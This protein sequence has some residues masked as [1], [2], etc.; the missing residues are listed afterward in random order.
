MFFLDEHVVP[1]VVVRNQDLPDDQMLKRDLLVAT[2]F[3]GNARRI[4]VKKKSISSELKQPFRSS[5]KSWKT[6]HSLLW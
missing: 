4:P 6:R 2:F 1:C 5:S 3:S